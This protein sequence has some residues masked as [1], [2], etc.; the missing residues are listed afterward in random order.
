MFDLDD[1]SYDLPDDLIAQKPAASRD[2]SLLLVVERSEGSFSDH[3][4]SEL[5]GLL[6]AGDLL[7]VNNTQVFPARLY[8]RKESGGR[9][10][11]LVT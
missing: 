8:G 6:R 9:I 1:Y 5:P 7:V 3:R 11:V 4:F 10:E 2:R